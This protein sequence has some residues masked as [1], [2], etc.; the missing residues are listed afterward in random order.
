MRPHRDLYLPSL[1]LETRPGRYF[2]LCFLSGRDSAQMYRGHSTFRPR[3]QLELSQDI[4]LEMS[5]G[6]IK[7]SRNHIL[8]VPCIS[9]YPTEYGSMEDW[10]RILLK[11]AR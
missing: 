2:D 9:T 4:S 3:H 1:N 8:P 6:E 11:T 5:K 10:L 7:N